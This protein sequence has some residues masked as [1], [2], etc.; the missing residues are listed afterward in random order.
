MPGLLFYLAVY[1]AMNL[2]AFLTV[3]G[4]GRVL[5]SD[6]LD[7]YAGLGRRMPLAGVVLAVSLL[8]LAGVPPMGSFVG[9]A[10]LF[11]AAMG[12][13]LTWLAAAAAANTALSLFYYVRVLEV[14]YLRG[15]P[16]G[17]EPASPEASAASP[18]HP[19]PGFPLG[20]AVAAS[21]TGGATLLLGVVPQP[22]LSLAQRASAILGLSAMN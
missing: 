3:A 7:R 11:A 22:L 15:G 19:R 17:A 8:A 21:V 9:K 2:A 14:A 13:G 20:A 4:V 1:L 12:A 5:G 16:E 10:M 6:E 18:E